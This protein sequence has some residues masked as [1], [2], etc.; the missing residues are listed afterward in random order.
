MK[1]A[2]IILI[3]FSQYS[4]GSVF[5]GLSGNFKSATK[6]EPKMSKFAPGP[7]ILS[8][9]N[10]S[11]IWDFT[12]SVGYNSY[13]FSYQNASVTEKDVVSGTNKTYTLQLDEKY[14]LINVSIGFSYLISLTKKRRNVESV[15]K[16]FAE[17][18]H[19]YFGFNTTI[20]ITRLK[21]DRVIASGE[22]PNKL[23]FPPSSMWLP[24]A[25]GLN[26]NAGIKIEITEKFV[27]QLGF[28]Y[29]LLI[30]QGTTDE[31][32]YLSSFMNFMLYFGYRI[33]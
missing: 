27:T 10:L 29:G 15:G 16:I 11:D 19:P 3:L 6:K 24:E 13:K 28:G 8:L 9:V 33:F 2:I 26:V 12:L 4:F 30:P 31:N 5:L 25:M 17:K 18:I 1:L 21:T 20:Y 23:T 14:D 7:D 32:K 22:V